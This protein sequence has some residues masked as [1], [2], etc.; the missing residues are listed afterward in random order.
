M[1]TL[2]LAARFFLV[3]LLCGPAPIS[4]VYF[5]GSNSSHQSS[6]CPAYT[7]FPDHH[8]ECNAA[9]PPPLPLTYHRAH[10]G[11]LGPGARDDAVFTR[12]FL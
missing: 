11:D 5:A 10:P 3:C 12:I 4:R 2:L 6:P 7:N 1:F 9:Q 8:I